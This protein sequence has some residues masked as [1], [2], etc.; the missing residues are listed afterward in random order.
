MGWGVFFPDAGDLG[1]AVGAVGAF[2]AVACDVEAAAFDEGGVAAGAMRVFAVAE[3]AGDVA[4]V[5]VAQ[6][7]FFSEVVGAYKRSGGRSAGVLHFVVGMEC[8]DVPGH[9]NGNARDELGDA[10]KFVVAVVEAGDDQRDDLDPESH[11]VQALDGL[12]NVFQCAAEFTIALVVEGLE[13]NF[14]EGDVGLDV[15]EDLRRRI[16]VA[17]EAAF[18]TRLARQFENLPGPVCRDQRLVV[19]AHHHRRAVTRRQVHEILRAAKARHRH[20]VIV[21]QRLAGHPILAIRAMQVAAH[22][23]ERQRVPAGVGM[24]EGL[25]LDGVDLDAGDVAT[26]M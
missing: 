17:D 14:V 12:Q 24:K 11:V 8:G 1:V 6:S 13:I 15:F 18:E 26:G 2:H 21:A 5:D 7:G 3:A 20:G 22:H 23:P 9:V 16:A 10:A 19:G 4:G 25:L